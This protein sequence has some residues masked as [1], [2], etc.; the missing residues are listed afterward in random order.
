MRKLEGKLFLPHQNNIGDQNKTKQNKTKKREG[1]NGGDVGTGVRW[2]YF[3]KVG[4]S[5]FS[6][7]F[8]DDAFV[9]GL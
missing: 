7:I 8:G 5:F 9:F 1:G 3:G 4:N 6:N 2:I